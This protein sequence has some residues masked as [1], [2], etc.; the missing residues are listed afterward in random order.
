MSDHADSGVLEDEEI[1]L[2]YGG[3][4]KEKHYARSIAYRDSQDKRLFGFIT[5]SFDLP[6]EKIALI[7]KSGD[8]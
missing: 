6:I 4:T 8:K 7:Y 1:V 5:N 3:N 2:C